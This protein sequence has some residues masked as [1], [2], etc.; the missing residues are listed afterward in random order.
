MPRFVVDLSV[1]CLLGILVFSNA[2]D[3]SQVVSNSGDQGSEAT[4]NASLQRMLEHCNG[5]LELNAAVLLQ[6][7]DLF[8]R[9][10]LRELTVARPNDETIRAVAKIKTLESLTVRDLST[11]TDVVPLAAL[12]QLQSLTLGAGPNMDFTSLGTL[13][14]LTSLTLYGHPPEGDL[15]VLKQLPRLTSLELCYTQG[16][17]T[18]SIVGELKSLTSFCLCGGAEVR[19][20]EP[21]A[22]LN[23]LVELNLRHCTGL[24]DVSHLSKIESLAALTIRQCE[25]LSDLRPLGDCKSLKSLDLYY[26]NEGDIDLSP[27]AT[28]QLESLSIG[29]HAAWRGLD[30]VRSLKT[31]SCRHWRHEK[32]PAMAGL[33]N[34]TTLDLAF[35]SILRD[36]T[37]LA[38]LTSLRTARS[39]R[40]PS[41]RKP[42]APCRP[43]L[44]QG[45]ELVQLSRRSGPDAAGRAGS[46]DVAHHGGTQ[47]CPRLRACGRT[48]IAPVP[49]HEHHL[50]GRQRHRVLGPH[51]EPRV[52]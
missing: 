49:E 16:R 32:L 19:N 4:S 13:K 11:V 21:L 48:E 43:W 8:A 51:A 3:R 30:Q 41:S 47:R 33:E 15:Q 29:G 7:A 1:G 31:L 17:R 20:L 36:L 34:L 25:Q 9:Y 44:P 22:G 23:Q 2:C 45:A 35:S 38:D 40:V 46:P 27:L 10:D 37:P 52:L 6:H 5:S 28:T 24:N 18:L 42:P 26:F 50:P 14:G 39:Q 12:G